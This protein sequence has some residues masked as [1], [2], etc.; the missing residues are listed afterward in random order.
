M[1]TIR[2]QPYRDCT[3]SQRKYWE[4][5]LQNYYTYIGCL[6]DR[7]YVRPFITGY[8]NYIA[9]WLYIEYSRLQALNIQ[10]WTALPTII[11]MPTKWDVWVALSTVRT[12]ARGQPEVCR[13]MACNTEMGQ[14]ICSIIIWNIRYVLFSPVILVKVPA[15]N[16]N[17]H[18]LFTALVF[19]LLLSWRMAGDPMIGSNL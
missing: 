15:Q 13:Q 10:T 12:L 9:D 5:S 1:R 7:N 16:W 17:G 2:K 6:K 14:R 11:Y 19:L 4:K 3:M 18:S 8:L